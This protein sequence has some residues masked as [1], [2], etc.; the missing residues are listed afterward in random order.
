MMDNFYNAVKRIS[1]I[2]PNIYSKVTMENWK[3][4]RSKGEYCADA[5]LISDHYIR[6]G[7]LL[8]FISKD[9]THFVVSLA[10][11][12]T[13]DDMEFDSEKFGELFPNITECSCYL[14]SRICLCYIQWAILL[15]SDEPISKKFPDMYEPLIKLIERG[16]GQ[17]TLH[18]GEIDGGF[19]GFPRLIYADRGNLKAVDISDQ[20]L[21][22]IINEVEHAEEFLEKYKSGDSSK[23]FCLRCKRGLIIQSNIT[24]WGYQW[25]KIKCESD[26]CFNKNFS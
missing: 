1:S 20:S 24:E 7:K 5:V 17:M 9:Y 25:Y 16:G 10:E 22:Q 6:V 19:G 3:S 21:N 26:D 15:D 14:I 12:I 11:L 23:H 18:H 4:F 2:D 13:G 8:Q